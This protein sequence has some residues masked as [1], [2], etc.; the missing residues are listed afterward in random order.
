MVYTS[1]A[2]KLSVSETSFFHPIFSHLLRKILLSVKFRGWGRLNLNIEFLQTKF[3]NFRFNWKKGKI[4]NT[5][6]VIVSTAGVFFQIYSGLIKLDV[7][8]KTA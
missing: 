7:I 8:Y 1:K 2:I 4:H 6:H 3:S 5:C